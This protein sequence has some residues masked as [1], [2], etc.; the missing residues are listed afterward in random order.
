MEQGGN[1]SSDRR[2]QRFYGWWSEELSLI[3]I[4]KLAGIPRSV[5]RGA[6]KVLL[7]LEE[8]AAQTDDKQLDLFVASEASSTV[9]PEEELPEEDPTLLELRDQLADVSMDDL[10]PRQ[11]WE[12]LADLQK[13]AKE[14]K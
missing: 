4:S 14:T 7:K 12:L 10:S 13:K 5:I 3:H 2:F 8:R 11:A 6:Q 9:F 1:V